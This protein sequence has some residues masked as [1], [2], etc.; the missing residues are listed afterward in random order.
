MPEHGASDEAEA[1]ARGLE[2]LEA[3]R[4][5]VGAAGVAPQIVGEACHSGR[6]A[7]AIETQ[8]PGRRYSCM[9]ETRLALLEARGC[10]LMRSKRPSGQTSRKLGMGEGLFIHPKE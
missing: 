8:S 1:S 7:V 6:W 3:A 5:T 9:E 10:N 4:A 2:K